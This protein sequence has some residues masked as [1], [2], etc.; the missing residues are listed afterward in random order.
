MIPLGGL[1]GIHRTRRVDQI[2]RERFPGPFR[3]KRIQA[4]V[5]QYP[6]DPAEEPLCR[7]ER[8]EMRVRLK[9]RVLGRVARPVGRRAP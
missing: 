1:D 3:A 5:P 8:L 6:V 2:L 9:E 4:F 7:I